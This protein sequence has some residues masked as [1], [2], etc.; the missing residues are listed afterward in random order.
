MKTCYIASPYTGQEEIGVQRQILIADT[1]IE[2]GIA[3]I[4]PLLFHYVHKQFPKDYDTW[5]EIDL[6]LLK[7]CDLLYRFPQPSKGADIEELF[8]N[9]NGIKVYN[10]LD[11]LIKENGRLKK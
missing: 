8:A 6:A 2:A 10:S 4:A 3:P 7:K 9:E 11:K 1:L 5:M